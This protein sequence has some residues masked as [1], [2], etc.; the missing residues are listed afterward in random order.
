VVACPFILSND[1][2]SVCLCMWAVA[3][4]TVVCF[5]N[6]LAVKLEFPDINYILRAENADLWPIPQ[7]RGSD[8]T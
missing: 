5:K 4:Q 2:I 7:A 8:K 1:R 6:N 3:D